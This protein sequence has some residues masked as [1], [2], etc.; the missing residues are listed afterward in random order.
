MS[1]MS[2][3]RWQNTAGALRDCAHDL[4]R[5]VTPEADDERPGPLSADEA[6]AR[7]SLF[8]TAA[9]MM[10]LVGVEVDFRALS[11]ALG[12]LK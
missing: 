4:E 6:A 2:Y 1:N 5:R 10:E 12:E 8:E 7:R 11:R 3:C 9:S